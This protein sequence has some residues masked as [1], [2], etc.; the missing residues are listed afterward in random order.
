MAQQMLDLPEPGHS[1]REAL[2]GCGRHSN[3]PVNR[4]EDAPSIFFEPIR[5]VG[6]GPL[7]SPYGWSGLTLEPFR[8]VRP[9]LSWLTVY[10]TVR[11]QEGGVTVRT[12]VDEPSVRR[13]VPV[14]LCTVGVNRTPYSSLSV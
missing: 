8:T 6:W 7:A 3:R 5:V 2:A 10:G 4:L 11:P 9:I 1:T 13:T 12:A 14:R